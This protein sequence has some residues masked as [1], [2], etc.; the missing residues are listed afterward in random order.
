MVY[1]PEDVRRVTR[2]AVRLRRT[3]NPN[4][5]MVFSLMGGIVADG[6]GQWYNGDGKKALLF[7]GW[8]AISNVLI[9]RGIEDNFRDTTTNALGQPLPSGTNK[10]PDNDNVFMYIGLFS[11]MVSYIAATVDARN[12]A[13][14]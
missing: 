10:D 2:E 13:N 3:K 9:W 7:F 12:S 6:S 8:S 1:P 14:Q 5:A 11:R 4:T